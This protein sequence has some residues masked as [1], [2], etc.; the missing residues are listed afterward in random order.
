VHSNS[1]A[2]LLWTSKTQPGTTLAASS[3]SGTPPIDLRYAS[4][5]WLAVHVGAVTGTNPTLDVYL[6]LQ[7]AAGNWFTQVLHANP[8]LTAAGFASG[9]AGLHLPSGTGLAPVVLPE[10]GRV[11][12]TV[13]GTASPTF[14]NTVISLYGR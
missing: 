13:G 7:D 2:K 5:L 3:D 8:Q 1:S 10:Y 9:S 14:T 6:D 12:W 4:S 11:S